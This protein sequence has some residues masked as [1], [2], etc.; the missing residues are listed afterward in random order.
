[1][2]VDTKHPK[3]IVN[4]SKWKKC[5]LIGEGSEDDV[6]DAGTDFLPMLGGA[7]EGVITIDD[8]TAYNNYKNRG[9]LFPAAARSVEGISGAVFRKDPIVI[10]PESKKEYLDRIGNDGTDLFN[11]AKRLFKNVLIV[12]RHGMLLDLPKNAKANAEPFLVGYTAESIINWRTEK[13]NG[14][15]TLTMVVLKEESLIKD[16]A[17]SY[18][19]ILEEK[20]RVLHLGNPDND[21]KNVPVYYMDLWVKLKKDGKD[22]YVLEDTKI[23]TI[24]GKKLDYIPFV[25]FSATGLSPNVVQSPI[26]GIVNIN[27]SHYMSTADLEHGLHKVALPV[28]WVAG[29]PIDTRLLIGASTAWVSED[30]SAKAGYLEFTGKGLGAINDRLQQKE[31]QMAMLGARM[32]ETQKKAVES[33]DT[34]RIRKGGEESITASLAGTVSKGLC[35][36]LSWAVEWMG[37]PSGEVSV[38][39]NKDYTNIEMS[40]QMLIALMSALQS[41]NISKDTWIYNLQRGEL[42]PDGRTVEEE[43]DLIDENISMPSSNDSDLDEIDD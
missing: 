39:L 17:D 34:H 12:G 33:A 2:P 19:S 23:P 28:A 20:I 38:E 1:M 3:Y 29:F 25:F 21:N 24:R 32:L 30:P 15:E 11:V 14:K 10:F 13:V 5:R 18:N 8:I 4:A 40:P 31:S 26:L 27:I 42:L 43:L 35:M 41:G 9:S 36:M 16:P 37:V 22:I 7:Q 6:K